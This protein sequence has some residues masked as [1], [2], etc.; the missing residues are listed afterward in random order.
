MSN[1]ITGFVAASK[2]E[3]KAAIAYLLALGFKSRGSTTGYSE[4]Y[5]TIV[6]PNPQEFNLS[7][8]GSLNAT[9]LKEKGKGEQTFAQFLTNDLQGLKTPQL[10]LDGGFPSVDGA[11]NGTGKF[12]VTFTPDYLQVGCVRVTREQLAEINERMKQ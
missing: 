7:G 11:F 2:E 12:S 5:K 9:W 1:V 8:D 4:S 6:F 3:T 10:I